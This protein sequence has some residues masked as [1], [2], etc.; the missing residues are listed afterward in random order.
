MLVCWP[1]PCWDVNAGAG[2]RSCAGLFWRTGNAP[3]WHLVVNPGYSGGEFHHTTEKNISLNSD[4]NDWS[5]SLTTWS[6]CVHRKQASFSRMK[7]GQTGRISISV[8]VALHGNFVFILL[9]AQ[10]LFFFPPSTFYRIRVL[11]SGDVFWVCLRAHWKSSRKVFLMSSKLRKALLHAKKI[12]THS[13]YLQ[14][15]MRISRL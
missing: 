9:F 3:P 14:N 2:A 1:E 6:H 10:L 13:S 5:L 7:P 15:C 4:R 11:E 8:V 12:N